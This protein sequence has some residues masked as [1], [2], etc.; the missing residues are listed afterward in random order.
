MRSVTTLQLC[1]NKLP[2]CLTKPFF[3]K[4]ELWQ[5]KQDS[6]GQISTGNAFP[7]MPDSRKSLRVID[8]VHPPESSLIYF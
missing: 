1:V 4:L 2:F 8:Y 5:M 6:I 3:I 7:E